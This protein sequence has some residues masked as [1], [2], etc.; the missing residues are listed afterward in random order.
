[1][2]FIKTK[3]SLMLL[4]VFS[5]VAMSGCGSSVS[6]VDDGNG[7]GGTDPIIPPV[8]VTLS[9]IDLTLADG[10]TTATV[11]INVTGA[12]VATGTY[13][14]GTEKDLTTEVTYVVSD[15]NVVQVNADAS[16]KALAAGDAIITATLDGVESNDVDVKVVNATLVSINIE[17]KN[18]E[19]PL[20]V[21]HQYSA[22]G[23][24]SDG[25]TDDITS[26][27]DWKSSAAKVASF[28][29]GGMLTANAVGD[30][31][32]T[33]AL[34]SI[35]A[36]TQV[37][38]INPTLVKWY[39]QGANSVE[40]GF[41]TKLVAL[42]D[43]DNGKTYDV[44]SFV[45]WTSDKTQNASVDNMGVVTGVDVGLAQITATRKNS[46]EIKTHN[47]SV[48]N[49]VFE[50]IQIEL[51]YNP[52]APNPITDLDV[53]LGGN[54]YLTAWGYRTNGDRVYVGTDVLWRSADD[55]IAAINGRE[56]SYVYGI[57][58]GTTTVTATLRGVSTSINVT[59]VPGYLFRDN[60]RWGTDVMMTDTTATGKTKLHNAISPDPDNS[61]VWYY[62]Q[63]GQ[64]YVKEQTVAQTDFSF[65][66]T[67]T[68][69]TDV[70][71]NVYLINPVT[72]T[73]EK[74]IIYSDADWKALQLDANKKTWIIRTNY[75]EWSE[76]EP[77]QTNFVLRLGS[78]TYTTEGTQFEIKKYV[79]SP[80]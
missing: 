78:S 20:H 10:S 77:R 65:A 54:K 61:A 13:S 69:S 29:V 64:G 40:K 17:P 42:G 59:V 68:G 60:V 8:E 41:T 18:T 35:D 72:N 12:M 11:H 51:G 37:T 30:S 71:V 27:V 75:F 47:I 43:F 50:Y 39:I 55:T 23:T 32:I 3:F 62:V 22:E 48:V 28:G 38:V 79:V 57:A 66:A 80:K 1:M 36:I 49:E 2:N 63:E 21:D 16:A 14:D 33:A 7:G 53:G 6:T 45:T 9:K 73:E 56:S 31:N 5:V 58:P 76:G 70:Y 52:D 25:L 74:E 67:L 4:A 19:L 44:S 24:Y 26:I 15:T 34:G 46:T